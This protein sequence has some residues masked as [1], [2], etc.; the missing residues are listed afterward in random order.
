MI[1]E[2][3]NG[4]DRGSISEENGSDC[5]GGVSDRQQQA[6]SGQVSSKHRLQSEG[7][8]EDDRRGA[9]MNIHVRE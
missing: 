8:K 1:N 7:R 4:E 5:A 2:T 6:Q 3:A 9:R